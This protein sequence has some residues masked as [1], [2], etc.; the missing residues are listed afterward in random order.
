MS[1]QYVTF[2]SFDLFCVMRS[3]VTLV[4]KCTAFVRWWII[5]NHFVYKLN[6]TRKGNSKDCV[7]G[8]SDGFFGCFVG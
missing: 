6:R 7:A 2:S 8:N 4:Y 5:A 1:K 3:H